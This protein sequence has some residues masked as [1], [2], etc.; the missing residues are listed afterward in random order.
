MVQ[1][2]EGRR[3]GLRSLTGQIDTTTQ[4]GRLIFHIFGRSFSSSVISFASERG[5]G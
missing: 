4:N 1:E 3:V 2:H 5:P